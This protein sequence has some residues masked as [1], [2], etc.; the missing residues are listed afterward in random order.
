[1]RGRCN[2]VREDIIPPP[3]VRFGATQRE[4]GDEAADYADA[5][6]SRADSRC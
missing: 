4:T 3:Q 5:G 2:L 1:M 6:G